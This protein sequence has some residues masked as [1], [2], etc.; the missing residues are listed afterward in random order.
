VKI[1]LDFLE[2]NKGALVT[3]YIV[4]HCFYKV[5]I[6]LKTFLRRQIV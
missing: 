6:I 5:V 4:K 3:K 1:I 2:Q